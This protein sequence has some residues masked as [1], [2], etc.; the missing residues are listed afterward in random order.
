[1]TNGQGAYTVEILDESHTRWDSGR[2]WDIIRL[3]KM[4]HN[5]KLI[6]C[7]L[8]KLFH[9]IFWTMVDHWQLK[10]W[11]AKLQIRVCYYIS[12]FSFVTFLIFIH[13]EEYLG[14][15]HSKYKRFGTRLL[16][17]LR[18]ALYEDIKNTSNFIINCILT[19]SHL[20]WDSYNFSGNYWPLEEFIFHKEWH[21]LHKY[22]LFLKMYYSL[23]SDLYHLKC[24]N[25]L[26]ENDA[27]A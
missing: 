21:S 26:F 20:K 13:I 16:F 8:I 27:I 24:H 10:L 9:L 7:W 1:M 4:A 15:K 12:I 14:K 19:Y 22:L 5:L 2:V 6:N 18:V 25:S 17:W 23:V 3:L 11:K